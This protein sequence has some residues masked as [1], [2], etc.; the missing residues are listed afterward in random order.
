MG[1][2]TDTPIS[3]ISYLEQANAKPVGIAVICK[4]PEGADQVKRQLYLARAKAREEGN[5][6]LDSL[7]ISMSPHSDDILFIYKSEANGRLNDGD[8]PLHE[9][10]ENA[11]EGHLNAES[12]GPETEA[13]N[14]ETV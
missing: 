5:T 4:C 7:S 13:S 9:D 1:R 12:T 6:A 2:L 3:W 8:S 10:T 11:E 14:A